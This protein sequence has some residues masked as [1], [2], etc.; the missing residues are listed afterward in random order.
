[1]CQ[2]NLFPALNQNDFLGLLVQSQSNELNGIERKDTVQASETYD[3]K[4][5]FY[6]SGDSHQRRCP[7]YKIR[8]YLL[9]RIFNV[10]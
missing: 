9:S 10:I 1:M 2:D 3:G 6:F 8:C 4:F 5:H 7:F